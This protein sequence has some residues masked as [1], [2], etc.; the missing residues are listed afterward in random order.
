M[1]GFHLLPSRPSTLSPPFI[2]S[3]DATTSSSS[4]TSPPFV[5]F[6]GVTVPPS[7]WYLQSDIF[8]CGRGQSLD[9]SECIVKNNYKINIRVILELD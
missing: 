8:K 7:F 1:L 2:L 3:V 5:L 6:V 9:K 4:S